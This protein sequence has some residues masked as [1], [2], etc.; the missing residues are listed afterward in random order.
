MEHTFVRMDQAWVVFDSCTRSEYYGDLHKLLASPPGWVLRYDYKE[1]WLSEETAKAIRFDKELP[2]AILF[3]YAQTKGYSRGDKSPETTPAS[4]EMLW[5]PTR[6]GHMLN[7]V[8]DAGHFFFDFSVD[9][10]PALGSAGA[11]V[12]ELFARGETPFAKW[13]AWTSRW[14]APGSV[15]EAYDDRCWHALVDSLTSDPCQ[16]AGD[17]FWRIRSLKRAGSDVVLA[18]RTSREM[19]GTQTRQIKS[20]FAVEDAARYSAEIVTSRSPRSRSGGSPPTY[21]IESASDDDKAL[22]I[23]GSAKMS[24]RQYTADHLEF[25]VQA[26][27]FPRRLPVEVALNTTP[28]D[29][30]WP[31]GP[32]LRLRFLVAK[33]VRTMAIALLALVLATVLGLKDI[34]PILSGG[35]TWLIIL[36]AAGSVILFAFGASLWTGKLTTK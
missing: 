34:K 6:L 25:E 35:A 8:E 7:V 30:D 5:I 17:L 32:E 11:V 20:H 23:V 13:V 10:Y 18:P 2:S 1:K 27:T 21:L 15:D 31:Q 28:R 9:G 3:L 24:A 33:P 16:F 26:L 14:A 29:G 22:K 19:Q 4:G 36:Q 12:D